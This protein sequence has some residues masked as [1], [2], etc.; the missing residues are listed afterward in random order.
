MGAVAAPARLWRALGP[1]LA[2]YLIAVE[3]CVVVLLIATGAATSPTARD[4]SIASL[5]VVGAAI[6][7]E[8]L[9]R[10]G[11]PAGGFT[12]LQATWTL[13]IVLLLPP[14]YAIAAP[15][16]LAVL[17]QL[18]YPK[19]RLHRKIFSTAAVMLANGIAALACRALLG[20]GLLAGTS[21]KSWLEHPIR[22]TLIGFSVALIWCVV[23]NALGFGAMRLSTPE[24]SWRQL[25]VD[26]ETRTL[27][28]VECCCGI[29]VTLTVVVSPPLALVV[30]PPMMLLQ[31]SIMH[32]QLT[33]A[34]RTDAKTGLLNAAAWTREAERHIAASLRSKIPLG[35][36]LLDLDHFKSVNDQYGHLIGD[37]V[38]R[39]VADCMSAEIRS[40]DVA[41][42][43][44]GEE[45]VLLL[46]GAG[47]VRS[48]AVAERLRRQLDV[49]AVATDDGRAVHVTMSAGVAVFGIDGTD[50]TD[51][52]AAAD[53]ALYRAKAAGRNQVHRASDLGR[54]RATDS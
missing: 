24:V 34:A 10:I 2:G 22:L 13:P 26:R 43:F 21:T 32:G 39:S 16:P 46:P 9:R 47:P 23:N 25:I 44:G 1:T 7:V 30:V 17:T 15:I 53:A 51:L 4:M 45:F 41:G 14:V 8:A 29:V 11:E 5:L 37:R 50:L 33:A 42:R 35:V 20:E 36:I 18:A 49:Q 27:D 19:A 38:L 6:N 3:A 54:E 40:Y 12:D 52:L 48:L 28:A 31:R